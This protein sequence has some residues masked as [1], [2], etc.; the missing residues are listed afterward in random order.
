MDEQREAKDQYKKFSNKLKHHHGIYRTLEKLL[1][2]VR[3]LKNPMIVLDTSRPT[4]LSAQDKKYPII[5]GTVS[6][7]YNRTCPLP[8]IGVSLRHVDKVPH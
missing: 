5:V 1:L 3:Y 6:N 4:E 7:G 2:L 8:R